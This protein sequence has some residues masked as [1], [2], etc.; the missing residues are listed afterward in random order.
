[1]T[2]SAAHI[3]AQQMPSEPWEEKLLGTTYSKQWQ[4]TTRASFNVE[5]LQLAMQCGQVVV[6]SDGSFMKGEG[7]AAWT[8]KGKN[9]EE[10]V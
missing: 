8:I 7:A 10:G 2:G 5:Q 4:V 6:V 3:P 9:K 1:L